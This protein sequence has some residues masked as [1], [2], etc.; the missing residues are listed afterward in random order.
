MSGHNKW[1]KIK[2]KK[3]AS[4]AQKSKIFSKLVKLIQNESKASGGNIDS[5]SLK[6][7]V[8]KAKAANMPSDNISRAIK[9]GAESN[10]TNMEQVVY[11]AYGPGGTALIIDG[12]TDNKNKTAQEIRHI[13]TRNGFSLAATGSASWAFT[14]TGA[15]YIPNTMVKISEEDGEKLNKLIEE[16]EENEDVQEVYT[17]AE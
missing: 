12:L 7:A 4:D 2:H 16:F 14:K 3:E 5:P 10:S 11:E 9:K 15:E 17:N 6:S 1:S 13:L 8:E